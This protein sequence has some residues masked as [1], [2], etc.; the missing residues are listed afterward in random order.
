M[1]DNLNCS[2]QKANSKNNSKNYDRIFGTDGVRQLVET[3]R[4]VEPIEEEVNFV[5]PIRETSGKK[6]K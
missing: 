3:G 2:E 6:D 1:S 4:W 5:G